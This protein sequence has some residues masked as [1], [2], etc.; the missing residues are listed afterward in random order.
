MRNYTRKIQKFEDDYTSKN[1]AEEQSFNNN[2]GSNMV[3]EQFSQLN[4]G[5]LSFCC[6]VHTLNLVWIHMEVNILT[7]G[8]SY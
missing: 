6:Q 5:V 2:M 4:C 8:K 7:V 1:F 3:K